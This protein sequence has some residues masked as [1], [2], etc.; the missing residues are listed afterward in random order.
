MPCYRNKN[1]NICT[2]YHFATLFDTNRRIAVYSVYYFQPSDGG[3]RE[4]RRFVE[5]QVGAPICNIY[6]LRGTYPLR[7][8]TYVLEEPL[9]PLPVLV[10]LGG[11]LLPLTAG[12]RVPAS[13][14][15]GWVL[16]GKEHP[17]VYPGERQALSED[18][19]HSGFD[20]GHLNPNGH[21]PGSKVPGYIFM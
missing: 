8:V 10:E 1:A 7:F 5:P 17:G 14:D 12:G 4:K 18:Y 11:Y 6:E 19:T 13:R 2:R 20:R 15:E 21:H 3:G 16:V 9:C